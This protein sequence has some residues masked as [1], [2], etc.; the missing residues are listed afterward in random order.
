MCLLGFFLLG[1]ASCLAQSTFSSIT[2]VVADGSGALVPNAKVEVRNV[3]T[4]CVFNADSNSEG[5]Y[6]FSTLVDGLYTLKGAA[7][8]FTDYVVKDIVL[9]VRE[10]RR[11]N[12]ALTLAS[13]Q[14][15]VEI[16]AGATLIVTESGKISDTKSREDLWVLPLTL[17]RTWDYM[18]MT[19]QVARSTT[20]SGDQPGDSAPGVSGRGSRRSRFDRASRCLAE[21]SASAVYLAVRAY[22]GA[23]ALGHRLSRLLHGDE[24]PARLVSARH[25][26]TSRGW[27]AL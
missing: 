24:H 13:T 14:Q 23:P 2:G 5:L 19:P 1:W 25:Q 17:R 6:T 26:S 12:I 20:E 15:T 18:T 4:G 8:G 16:S 3:W 22:G 11:I 27:V 9:A 21:G 10:T 7:P